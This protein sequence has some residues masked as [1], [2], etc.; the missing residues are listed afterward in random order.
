MMVGGPVQCGGIIEGILSEPNN[1]NC[2]KDIRIYIATRFDINYDFVYQMCGERLV[3]RDA[4]ITTTTTEFAGA[5]EIPK[6]ASEKSLLEIIKNKAISAW[7]YVITF[8]Y[9]PVHD[10]I[11]NILPTILKLIAIL[12]KFKRSKK[13]NQLQTSDCTPQ[14]YHTIETFPVSRALNDEWFG[15]KVFS[16]QIDQLCFPYKSEL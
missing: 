5:K 7:T 12:G 1:A 15:G 4:M 14:R 6:I 11:W 8:H 3:P 9:Q 16:D 2:Q 10:I 13:K